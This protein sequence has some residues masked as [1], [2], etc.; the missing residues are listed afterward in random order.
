MK[1]IY[2]YNENGQVI[3]NLNNLSEAELATLNIQRI[4]TEM[5]LDGYLYDHRAEFLSDLGRYDFTWYK[6]GCCNYWDAR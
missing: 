1:C 3:E 2:Y 6:S 4:G 5:E